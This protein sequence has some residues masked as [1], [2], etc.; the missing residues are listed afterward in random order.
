MNA[1]QSLRRIVPLR[2][3][4][5]VA[6]LFLIIVMGSAGLPAL[7][8]FVG[9][10]LT[11]F[12]TFIAGDSFPANH[13]HFLPAVRLLAALATT[14]VILGAVYLLY[15]FHKVFFGKLDKAKN[16]NLPDLKGHELAVFIPLVFAIVAGGLFPRQLLQVMEPSVQ[17]FLADFNKH[18][19]E[20]DGPPHVYGQPPPSSTTPPVETAAAP[21]PAPPA[22]M[23][24]APKGGA[25]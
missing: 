15:M 17:K 18:V 5:A 3:I 21:V 20:P 25:Q 11:L 1:V 16:G 4:L 19:D 7:S 23:P 8:G 2:V 12:G 22:G 13:P 9:E 14:G 6:G 24:P 10:F